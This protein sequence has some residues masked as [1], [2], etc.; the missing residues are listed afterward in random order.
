MIKEIRINNN[1]FL[2]NEET[3]KSVHEIRKNQVLSV[4]TAIKRKTNKLVDALI[5]CEKASYQGR[6]RPRLLAFLGVSRLET[7]REE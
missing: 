2:N 7:E 1:F 4:D 5:T 6:I 3:S